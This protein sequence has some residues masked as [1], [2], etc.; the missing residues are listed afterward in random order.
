MKPSLMEPAEDEN[1]EPPVPKGS[2]SLDLDNLD[3]MD[4]FK[5]TKVMANSPTK[6]KSHTASD[7]SMESKDRIKFADDMR[8][9]PSSSPSKQEIFVDAKVS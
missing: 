5:S 2:Y 3:S 9:S 6:D 7:Y 8:N 4:P 1:S